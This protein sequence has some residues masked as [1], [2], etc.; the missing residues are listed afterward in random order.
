MKHY[1]P[2]LPFSSV[3]FAN[4]FCVCRYAIASGDAHDWADAEKQVSKASHDGRKS[5][6]VSVKS[7]SGGSKRKAGEAVEEVLKEAEALKE[8]K[9][10]KGKH[11]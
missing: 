10:K 1:R 2:L 3:A 4:N 8:K 9:G 6:T 5:T 11:R 7:K